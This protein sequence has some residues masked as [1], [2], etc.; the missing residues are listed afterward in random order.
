VPLSNRATHHR[1]WYWL[2]VGLVLFFLIPFA[3]TDVVSLDRDVYYGVYIAAVF[4]FTGA[5]VGCE[6]DA[7]RAT[8][9]R[10]W[11]A[12]VGLG[13]IFAVVMVAIVVREP[14]TDRPEGL[15]FVA[16]IIWRGVLYGLADGVILSAFPILAVFAAFAGT[17]AVMRWHGKVA[18]G[19][20][21]LAVSLVF[22]AVYHAGYEDFRGEKVRKP[23]VGDAI[24]SLP[25]L[26]TLSPFGAPIAH[27]GLHVA[28]V[29]HSYDTDVFLPPHESAFD[30]AALQALLDSAVSGGSGVP[31]ATA[32]VESPTGA[33]SGAAG[34]ADVGRGVA[35]TS[36]ARMRLESVSKIYTAVL[37]YQLAGQGNL[38]LADPVGRWLPG[39]LPYGDRI[40]IAQLLSHR[41][42]LIDNNDIAADPDRYVARVTDG[43]FKAEL[44]ALRVRLERDPTIDFSPWVWIRLA[45]YQP[46][47]AQPGSQ[48]HYSNIGFEILGVV[49]ERAGG[50]ALARLYDE[51]IF[52]PIGLERTAYDPQGEISG[53][54]ARGYGGGRDTTA[55]HAGVGAEGGIVSTAA[56]TARF[57][58]ALMDGEL[59]RP[60]QLAAMK[61]EF[62]RGG[63]VAGC[64]GVAFGHSGGGFGFKT[65][66]WV[67]GDGRRV[68]VLLLN[69]RGDTSA[70]FRAGS[71]MRRLYCAAGDAG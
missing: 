25:T 42:G 65:N 69:G 18:V 5:W 20:L 36:D 27:A 40:T 44:A 57:L 10:N 19:A 43:D 35:M 4:A 30:G 8:L 12:G 59:L 15:A 31:G 9:T 6:L 7:R 13:A 58:T 23:V 41:S 53:P 56:E 29:V 55:A 70:D 63:D 62:W 46:L 16:A 45:A 71:L 48:Y 50:R 32:Y 54:H 1:Q 47:L 24:W 17:R 38:Q 49:A 68:A 66:V 52:R 14:A 39:V 26:A 67:S 37:I 22:T 64:G 33:W 34:V 60:R 11:R 3:L 51:R 61:A 2:G 21:A 28:A